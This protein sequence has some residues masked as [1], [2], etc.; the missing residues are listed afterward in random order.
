M[1]IGKW[2]AYCERH[3]NKKSKGGKGYA[4][5]NEKP[6]TKPESEFLK[7]LL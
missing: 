4:V 7:D 3:I 6:L 5:Y 1:T 2:G